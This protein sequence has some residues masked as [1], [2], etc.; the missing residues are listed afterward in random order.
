MVQTIRE[1]WP[2]DQLHH[3][4]VQGVGMLDAVDRRD[5][6]VVQRS[7]KRDSRSNRASR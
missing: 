3:E 6:R 1:R 2:L 7:K 5:V 4:R